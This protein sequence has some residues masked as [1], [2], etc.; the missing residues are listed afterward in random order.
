VTTAVVM[1]AVLWSIGPPVLKLISAPPAITT[2]LRLWMTAPFI[3]ASV[4]LRGNRMSLAILKPTILP[5]CCFGASALCVMFGLQHASVAVLTVMQALQ[6]AI[7]IVVAYLLLGERSTRRAAV[8]TAVGVGGVV[9]AV[10]GGRPD[11]RG[12]ALGIGLC[13]LSV[14]GFTAYYLVNRH[15]RST[16]SMDAMQF[17]AGAMLFAA[18]SVTP[19]ALAFSSWDGLRQVGAMDWVYLLFIATC[20]GTVS[21]GAM[22][23]LHGH[24]SAGR[25]SLIILVSSVGAILIAWPV[26]DEPVTIVQA[27]GSVIT[28]FAVTRVLAAPQANDLEPTDAKAI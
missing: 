4:Y 16:T 22:S 19:V 13:F 25:S 5:G 17:L 18:V 3:W 23:W 27:I 26:H 14:I 1:I 10:L 15:V 8:W 9:T 28:L 2:A 11:V 24:M 21:H 6:P 7:V 20:L 12:D